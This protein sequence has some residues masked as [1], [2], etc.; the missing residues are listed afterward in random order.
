[1]KP[2]NLLVDENDNIK[3]TD[4]GFSNFYQEDSLLDT[5]C[6]SP[7]YMPPEMIQGIKYPGPKVDVWGMGIILYSLITGQLPFTGED[8]HELYQNIAKARFRCP[9]YVDAGKQAN[10]QAPTFIIIIKDRMPCLVVKTFSFRLIYYHRNENC[11][12]AN[13]HSE[14]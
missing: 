8:V 1:L 6:G 13:A 7:C 9:H 12:L 3:I 2:E 5:F 11:H 4:F 10:E 14:F